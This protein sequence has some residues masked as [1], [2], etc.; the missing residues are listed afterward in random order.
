MIK[1]IIR[2]LKTLYNKES[3]I[4]FIFSFHRIGKFDKK[5]S[6]HLLHSVSKN[7]FKLQIKF[8]SLFGKFVSLDEIRNYEKLSKISFSISFDDCSRSIIEIIPFLRKK[9]IPYTIGLSTD[10]LEKG[11]SNRDKT[12]LIIKNYHKKELYDYVKEKIKNKIIIKEKNFSFYDITKDP[13]LDPYFIEKEIINPLI[14]KIDNWEKTI[15]SANLYLKVDDVKKYLIND[16]L[17]TI[18]NHS[19]KHIR[20]DNLLYEDI[21]K[22]TEISIDKFKKYLNFEPRYYAVPYGS[23]KQDLLVKLNKILRKHDYKGVLWV[24]NNG[25]I[26]NN[27]YKSQMVHLARIH[28]P[29]KFSEV[30]KIFIMAFLNSESKILNL[31]RKESNFKNKKGKVIH[32][33]NPDEALAFENLVS[34]GKDY[35]SDKKFYKYLFTDN[36]Y[37][38]NQPDYYAVKQPG[39]NYIESIGYN[40]FMNFKISNKKIK[41]IYWR[42]WRKL[43]YAKSPGR[44]T[45]FEAVN[46]TPIIALYKP[47]IFSDHVGAKKV[48]WKKIQIKGHIIDTCKYKNKKVFN[49]KNITIEEYNKYPDIIDKLI[50]KANKKYYFSIYRSK[51]FYK[52]RFDKYLLAK[53]K[54]FVI[55]EN[56]KPKGFFVTLDNDKTLFISDF[57]CESNKYFN[58]L[59]QKCI[60]YCNSNKLKTLG[61]ETSLKDINNYIEKNFKTTKYKFSNNY[62]F[63]KK[64][65]DYKELFEELDKNWSKLVFHETQASGDVLLR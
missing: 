7:L 56:E 30:L 11:Y 8:F 34:Q 64:Y 36:P 26:V 42:S 17:A 49:G 33:S 50:D 1:K 14:N 57:F 9:S 27:K 46:H 60:K 5:I 59:F 62:A 3:K 29:K 65:S 45:F 20:M 37:K 24:N 23:I 2:A 52:W 35:T 22:D 25:N 51:N 31:T 48:S 58:L 21:K 19:H 13:R 6:F 47:S 63:N 55:K 32:S 43:P 53:T 61:I 38:E 10:I 41:G 28:N 15:Q 18:V 39:S 54:Y 12:H 44:L 40:F 16:D 4:V